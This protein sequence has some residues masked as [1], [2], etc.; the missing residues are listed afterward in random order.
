MLF[1]FLK[2]YFTPGVSRNGN[3]GDLTVGVGLI[4]VC[5]R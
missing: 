2:A 5:N 4:G 3:G 1:M